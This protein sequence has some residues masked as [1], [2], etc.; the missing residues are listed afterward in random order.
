MCIR[1]RDCFID[2]LKVLK[3]IA[4]SNGYNVNI[5]DKLISKHKNKTKITNSTLHNAD[6][7]ISVEYTSLLPN[8]IRNHFKKYNI[9]VIFRTKNNTENAL[10]PKTPRN[11]DTCSGV[12]KIVCDDCDKFYVG[13]TGRRFEERFKN[14]CP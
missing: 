10:R 8:I 2:E 1:D 5:I 3:H 4:V 9:A 7:Y 6:R 14:T 12:Y 13:Q 11:V